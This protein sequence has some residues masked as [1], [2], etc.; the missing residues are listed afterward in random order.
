MTFAKIPSPLDKG[1]FRGLGKGN[2]PAL[3]LGAVVEVL[4]CVADECSTPTT[5]AVAVG[6][7]IPS[8]TEEG[9][10]IAR[11]TGNG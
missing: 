7:G 10:L 8:S 4:R 6:R 9:S 1:D 11:E 2:Q 5:P 3:A